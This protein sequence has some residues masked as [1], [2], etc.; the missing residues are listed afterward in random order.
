MGLVRRD[1]FGHCFAH[2]EFVGNRAPNEGGKLRSGIA[3][4]AIGD[5]DA[6]WLMPVMENSIGSHGNLLCMVDASTFIF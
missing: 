2:V 6:H 3:S 4:A 5:H 1:E